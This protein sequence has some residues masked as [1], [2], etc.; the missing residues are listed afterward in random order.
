MCSVLGYDDILIYLN[1]VGESEDLDQWDLIDAS[2]DDNETESED[3]ETMLND[4]MS[5]ALAATAPGDTR[6]K[7]SVQD[8]KFVKVRY[9]YVQGSK[10]FG[11]SKGKKMR[12]FCRAMESARKVYRK[13]DILRMQTDGVNSQLGHN[14][15]S[16]SLWLHKGG[17]NCFH[18]FERRIYLKRT[19][20]D[21]TPYAGGALTGVKKAS[22][23]EARKKGFNTKSNRFKNNKRV[24]EAQIDRADKGHHPSYVKPKK[25]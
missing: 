1:G 14:K 3:F 7:N 6:N 16:Y 20:N 23:K 25:K 22:I 19:K 13:E 12:P 2:I 15:Q 24:A 5:V 18:K 11:S 9:L 4:T 17:V 10:R 21:G 8:N